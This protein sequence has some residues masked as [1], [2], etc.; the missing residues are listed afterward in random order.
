MQQQQTALLVNGYCR[1]KIKFAIPKCIIH[2]LI[3][4]LCI[5]FSTVLFNDKWLGNHN[6]L[7]IDWSR[8][9]HTGFT[10]IFAAINIDFH[11]KFFES[12]SISIGSTFKLNISLETLEFY[13][14]ITNE[15]QTIKS[16]LGNTWKYEQS[17][18]F[19][20]LVLMEKG[21][22]ICDCWSQSSSSESGQ[23]LTI[24]LL[25]GRNIHARAEP[26]YRFIWGCGSIN[27]WNNEK[28]LQNDKTGMI[29][30]E[31]KE[32]IN[33]DANEDVTIEVNGTI[34]ALPNQ[35]QYIINEI[36]EYSQGWVCCHRNECLS[37]DD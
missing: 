17:Q 5:M 20:V 14:N 19:I 22:K 30:I 35:Q 27:L 15:I 26:I 12:F 8:F 1:Q 28:I 32:F 13:T 34:K 36:N 21:D 23:N 29:L 31:T 33:Y 16:F 18:H 9:I 7:N 25:N 37:F 6:K 2:L 24:F 11:L 10:S 4:Y 3:K